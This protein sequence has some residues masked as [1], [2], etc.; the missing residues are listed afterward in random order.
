MFPDHMQ[1]GDIPVGGTDNPSG[2][3]S[4]SAAHE[5]CSKMRAYS[6]IQTGIFPQKKRGK[7]S[8]VYTKFDFTV[9]EGKG[10]V[11][12][13]RDKNEG[14]HRKKKGGEI[15]FDLPHV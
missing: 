10:R 11:N 15:P 3:S 14:K 6:A 13:T 2:R 5:I 12:L 8:W 4:L 7:K 1:D 9:D